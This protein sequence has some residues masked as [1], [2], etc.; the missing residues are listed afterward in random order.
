MKEKNRWKLISEKT[1]KRRKK[2]LTK[3]ERE[4]IIHSRWRTSANAELQKSLKKLEKSSWQRWLSC[5]NI[6][7]LSLR[8][9]VVLWKLN[10]QANKIQMLWKKATEQWIKEELEKL[11]VKYLRRVWS[12]LRTNAGG[13]PNTCKSN[14]RRQ[15]ILRKELP[16][17]VADGWVTRGEPTF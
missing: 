8:R 11:F 17:L 9:Q 14:G 1:K 12:W 15:G 10:S 7:E 5:G 4:R 6:N 2:G 3:R 16:E 13:M